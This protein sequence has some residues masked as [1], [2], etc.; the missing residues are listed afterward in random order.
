[1]IPA[2]PNNNNEKEAIA[3]N[4]ENT[5]ERVKSN[6]TNHWHGVFDELTQNAYDAW[7]SNRILRNTI[8]E[9]Q[10]LVIELEVDTN[11][12]EFI[13]KDNAGGM[14]EETFFRNF[15]GLDTP[16]EEKQDGTAGGGYGRGAHVIFLS[17]ETTYAETR[18]DGFHDSLGI[19]LA[20]QDT[21]I[22]NAE[23]LQQDGTY[24]HVNNIGDDLIDKLSDRD[25][26]VSHIQDRFHPMLQQDNVTVKLTIDD[27]T[28]EI[29]ALELGDYDVIWQDDI[30]FT[31]RGEDL[32]L[33]NV[34][35]YDKTS[36]DQDIPF[37]GVAMFK[38]NRQADE[39][40]MR[41]ADYV[42]QNITHV[43]KIFGTCDA[44]SLCPEYEDNAHDSFNDGVIPASGLKD[45]L[46]SICH[47]V[48]SDKARDQNEVQ[49]LEEEA[50]TALNNQL[51]QH[52][53][54][55]NNDET[56]NFDTNDSAADSD[57]TN[58][59]PDQNGSNEEDP[60]SSENNQSNRGDTDDEDN[61]TPSITCR[62]RS[63]SFDPDSTVTLYWELSNPSYSPVSDFTITGTVTRPD[64][65]TTDLTPVP[66]TGVDAGVFIDGAWDIDLNGQTGKFIV[67]L[68]LH[69]QDTP[70]TMDDMCNTTYTYFYGGDRPEPKT[71]KQDVQMD[72]IKEINY[73]GED[74]NEMRYDAVLEDD[75]LTLFINHQHPMYLQ[76]KDRD[77]TTK[78]EHRKELSVT[79]GHQAVSQHVLSEE[80]AKIVGDH[81][82]DDGTPLNEAIQ[83]A[84]RKTLVES[85]AQRTCVAHQ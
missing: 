76:A 34:T 47:D 22:D 8:P 73:I 44:T 50:I 13:G 36:S 5:L 18:H 29:E 58:T 45:K 66:K 82:K 70:N 81:H 4:L 79:W 30:E 42:P 67:N 80:V 24:V 37:N 64:G 69:A 51:N 26:V 38:K 56:D 33:E 55:G 31:H 1:M 65:S 20:T 23:V 28:T 9:N 11:T 83:K 12:N 78:K 62:T 7:C 54:Y 14:P 85:T 17:G 53:P 16:G 3:F 71:K 68:Q 35:L 77:G 46:R 21:T 25:A 41:V 6:Y 43:N 15:A 19:E 72:F 2:K 74:P 32:V 40:F 10:E 63:R 57:G 61:T 27:D 75:G 49:E 84:I 48:F 52:N 39:L 60:D 59:N